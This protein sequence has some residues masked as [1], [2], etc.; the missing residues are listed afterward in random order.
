MD[1]DVF[2]SCMGREDWA[3]IPGAGGEK[4]SRVKIFG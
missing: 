4:K 1:H 2:V 3:I